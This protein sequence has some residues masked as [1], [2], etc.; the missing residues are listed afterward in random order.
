MK[1]EGRRQSENVE[2][3][4]AMGGAGTVVAGG[5][6]G[7]ILLL[8]VLSLLGVDVQQIVQQLPQGGQVGMPGQAPAGPGEFQ[9]S[10]EEERQA[11]FVRTILA[12]TEDV[13]TELFAQAGR[14]YEIPTLV[15]FRG[16]V[17]SRCGM[18]SAAVGPFYCPADRQVYIDLS[19]YHDLEEKLGAG[20]EFAQAYVVAHEV[21][22]H[23]Q[24]LL[25][26]SN[27]AQA[28]RRS[29]SEI[30][31][32]RESVRLELN[33]D[34]LAGV[35]AH[36]LQKKHQA[37][38]RQDIEDGINA[39]NAIGDDRLQ[40]QGQGYVVPDS[41]THGSSEQ[42]IRWFMAGLK[43]GRLDGGDTFSIDFDQL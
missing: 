4:R 16:R 20:G 30:N 26:L 8:I 12:D 3:R 10:P 17:E 29:G 36:H 7:M 33:A 34:Y 6:L 11:K 42:R 43:S 1:W 9:P 23:V 21:G 13:F 39:A 31:A 28:A 14:R 18:A 25:G 40:K 22:H 5:G 15:M 32:N 2:D 37:L 19:F 41:F 27:Q 24:Q 35:W 38:N